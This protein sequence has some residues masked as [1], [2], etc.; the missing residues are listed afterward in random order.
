LSAAEESGKPIKELQ[1]EE[2][3]VDDA[4]EELP[5]SNDPGETPLRNS[6][7][8]RID[9]LQAMK[10]S[11]NQRP[12]ENIELSS[13]SREV[14]PRKRPGP[15]PEPIENQINTSITQT[16]E[17]LKVDKM[18]HDSVAAKSSAKSTDKK[19]GGLFSRFRKSS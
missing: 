13:H 15:Q 16:L 1:L 11:G 9:M 18:P 4:A 2:A 8:L 3:A 10:N 19:P 12:S 14:E 5:A 7:A 17:A 6:M